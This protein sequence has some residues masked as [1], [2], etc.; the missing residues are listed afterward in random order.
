MMVLPVSRY[1]TL[2][3]LALSR[4]CLATFLKQ[5]VRGC[6]SILRL[7][8]ASLLSIYVVNSAFA[9]VYFYFARPQTFRQSNQYTSTHP[10][11][12]SHHHTSLAA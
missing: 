1:Q 12:A 6:F 5:F 11:S 9:L 8:V 4:V 2:V 10:Q 7:L 3:R